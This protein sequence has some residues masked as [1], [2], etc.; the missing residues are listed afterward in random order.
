M[1]L[2]THKEPTKRP[3]PCV[4]VPH[5]PRKEPRD[6]NVVTGYSEPT[7][8]SWERNSDVDNQWKVWRTYVGNLLGTSQVPSFRTFFRKCL[9][10][11]EVGS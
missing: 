6:E 5:L 8:F 1:S 10:F 3:A 7:R 2:D 11:P 9:T 4:A